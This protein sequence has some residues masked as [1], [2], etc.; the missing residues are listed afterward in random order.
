MSR[1]ARP[2][3]MKPTM[4]RGPKKVPEPVGRSQRRGMYG[5]MSHGTRPDGAVGDDFLPTG[6]H[7]VKV[8]GSET[9]VGKGQLLLY[10]NEYCSS[11]GRRGIDELEDEL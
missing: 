9:E 1:A 11:M 3:D 7:G 8:P 6:R 10:T 2:E 5:I 4:N